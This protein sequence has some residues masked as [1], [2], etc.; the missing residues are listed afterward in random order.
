MSWAAYIDRVQVV[1]LD[2]P[3]EVNVGEALAGVGAPVTEEPRLRV[4]QAQGLPQQGIGL[5]VLHPNAQ[6][7]VGPP[8]SVDLA[9]LVGIEWFTL[10]R[11]ARR[12]VCGE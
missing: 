9:E 12:A 5:Q 3:I 1:L 6:A 7:E 10:D 2:Q 11:R 4:L 8:I